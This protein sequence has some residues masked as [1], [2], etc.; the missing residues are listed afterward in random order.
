MAIT[1]TMKTL[2]T[3]EA[4]AFIAGVGR[5][6]PF[7]NKTAIN[8]TAKSQ[9]NNERRAMNRVFDRPT[10]FTL[11]SLKVYPFAT[12]KRQEARV[13]FKEIDVKATE[14]YLVPQVYGGVRGPTPF[15]RALRRANIL[16]GNEFVVPSRTAPL[17]KHGN[18][19]R[20]II[21]KIMAHIGA[22]HD[23]S[24]N[25]PVENLAWIKNKQSRGEYV[26]GSIGRAKGIWRT[27]G[28]RWLL[29]FHVVKGAPRYKKIFPFDKIAEKNYNE[30]FELDWDLAFQTAL[31][32]AE[33]GERALIGGFL[34]R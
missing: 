3:K 14:H 34:G 21:T 13:W 33:R 16:A 26:F 22:L 20:G 25:T 17:D 18:V 8:E 9:V 24:S 5:Q 29:I 10:R 6:M 11:N 4:R 7:I 27:A 19:R 15:E 30:N 23:R 12:K 31:R 1:L 2:G 32:S 28:D